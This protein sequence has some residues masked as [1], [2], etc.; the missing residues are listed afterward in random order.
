MSKTKSAKTNYALP[1]EPMSQQEFE[2]MIKKAEKGPFHAIAE[3]KA[4]IEKWKVKYS[5]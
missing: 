3:V 4:E 2:E 5:R 1:G